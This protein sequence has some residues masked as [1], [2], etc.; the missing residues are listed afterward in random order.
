[1]EEFDKIKDCEGTTIQSLDTVSY[2]DR[3]TKET[4]EG[5]IHN[6]I[7]GSFGIE[8]KTNRGIYKY[9]E[10]NTYNIKKKVIGMG[11][12]EQKATEKLIDEGNYNKALNNLFNSWG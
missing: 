9:D 10:V 7:G 2:I 4:T 1:M 11:F 8:S 6:M 12:E 3:E 5:I